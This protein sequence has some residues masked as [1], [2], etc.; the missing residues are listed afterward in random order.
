MLASHLCRF[1][2]DL[3]LSSSLRLTHILL[4]VCRSI[5]LS[6]KLQISEY[7]LQAALSVSGGGDFDR[8]HGLAAMHAR[9]A[10]F[11]QEPARGRGYLAVIFFFFLVT[12]SAQ[13]N[14]SYYDDQSRGTANNA[15][16][17]TES[18]LAVNL[19]Q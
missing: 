6:S 12:P 19:A 14:G 10:L 8:P 17:S 7:G 15:V 9:P 3:L 16:P 11:V 1:E 18:P 4:A 5:K 2:D 13:P